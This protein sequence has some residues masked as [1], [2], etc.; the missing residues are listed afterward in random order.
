MIFAYLRAA[1]GCAGC[2]LIDARRGVLDSDQQVMALLDQAAVSY[3]LVLT[4]ADELKPS[5]RPVR[6]PRRQEAANTPPR[7]PSHS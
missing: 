7:W 1:R 2:A 5:E 4:K 6:W 3:G